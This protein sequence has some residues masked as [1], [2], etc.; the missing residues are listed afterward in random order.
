V[1][2]L[3]IYLGGDLET[4]I[5]EHGGKKEHLRLYMRLITDMLTGLKEVHRQG[6]C[7]RD[8]KALNVFLTRGP[9]NEKMDLI[10]KLGD[11]GHAKEGTK[12]KESK[13]S[14]DKGTMLYWS[15]ERYDLLY[16]VEGAGYGPPA[17]VFGL[18]M[19]LFEM[20]TQKMPFKPNKV[21]CR[22]PRGPLPSWVDAKIQAV[23]YQMMEVDI[24]KRPSCE[25]ALAALAAL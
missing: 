19:I 13:F 12:A 18:G 24:D 8:L 15:P 20:L 7:H 21:D 2:F 3:F 14:N 23:C 10:A 17:D 22:G 11:F 4:F 25:Q 1:A 16:G 5:K 9:S 6:H